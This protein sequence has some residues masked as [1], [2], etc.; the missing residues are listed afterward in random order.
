M[1]NISKIIVISLLCISSTAYSMRKSA[2]MVALD[3][4]KRNITYTCYGY[5]RNYTSIRDQRYFDLK[6]LCKESIDSN[7]LL[8]EA[9]ENVDYQAIQIITKNAAEQ[10]IA[11]IND[12]QQKI[13]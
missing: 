5:T 13:N 7:I 1:K 10:K 3:I 4:L 11:K 2:P 12:H 9:F 8:H 6:K